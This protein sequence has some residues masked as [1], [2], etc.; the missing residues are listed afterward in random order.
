MK[1][2]VNQIQKILL[3]YLAVTEPELMFEFNNT[4][5]EMTVTHT[6]C[7]LSALNKRFEVVDVSF[8]ELFMPNHEILGVCL[9]RDWDKLTVFRCLPDLSEPNKVI[10]R[11]RSEKRRFPDQQAWSEAVLDYCLTYLKETYVEKWIRFE[12]KEQEQPYFELDDGSFLALTFVQGLHGIVVEI[13]DD[14]KEA[15]NYSFED[16]DIIYEGFDRVDALRQ[17]KDCINDCWDSFRRQDG[18]SDN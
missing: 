18:Q 4:V 12:P 2:T 9:N 14:E 11:Y 15:Y 6:G 1:Y 16:A 8:E 13:A 5:Y 3:D 7:S 17:L 10:E